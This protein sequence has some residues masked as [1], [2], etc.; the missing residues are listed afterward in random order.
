MVCSIFKAVPLRVPRLFIQNFPK[1][2][3]VLVRMDS[4]TMITNSFKI[5]VIKT[6]KHFH[7]HF[8]F[9]L[10]FYSLFRN[11]SKIQNDKNMKQ[12]FFY[13]MQMFDIKMMFTSFKK[14]HSEMKTFM[15]KSK[16]TVLS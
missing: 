8:F 6:W 10:E 5:P 12:K 15:N 9:A 14:V 2:K 11:I 3:E 7:R 4:P 13:S 16:K 1:W